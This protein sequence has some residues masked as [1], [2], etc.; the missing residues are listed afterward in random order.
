MIYTVADGEFRG[1]E[2]TLGDKSMKTIS[3]M[4]NN[5]YGGMDQLV[6]KIN[7]ILYTLSELNRR[8]P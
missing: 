1:V 6:Y 5:Q 8:V 7:H 2:I 3:F 4:V